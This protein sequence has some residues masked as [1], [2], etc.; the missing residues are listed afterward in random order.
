MRGIMAE[1]RRLIWW[2][3]SEA[4]SL[5]MIA[6]SG[7]VFNFKHRDSSGSPRLSVSPLRQAA[8]PAPN[9]LDYSYHTV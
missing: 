4:S 7:M 3:T 8:T 5:F 2:L 9:V 1:N 6:M